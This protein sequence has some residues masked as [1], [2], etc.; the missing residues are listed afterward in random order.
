MSRS[1]PGELTTSALTL[2]AVRQQTTNSWIYRKHIPYQSVFFHY[3]ICLR[4]ILLLIVL[5]ILKGALYIGKP[6]R[7]KT[8]VARQGA[9]V[10]AA[11]SKSI[12][13]PCHSVP[14]SKN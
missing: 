8:K 1:K 6:A 10:S 14:Q 5:R 3:N 9:T 7:Y 13:N 2:M 4:T 11:A 12:K